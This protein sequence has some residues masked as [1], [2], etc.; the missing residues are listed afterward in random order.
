MYRM[1]YMC[2]IVDSTS[3]VFVLQLIY[4][5]KDGGGSIGLVCLHPEL[6]SKSEKEAFDRI[7]VSI[8]SMT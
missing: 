5:Y 2:I 3:G 8:P 7:G 1:K 4:D 6:L